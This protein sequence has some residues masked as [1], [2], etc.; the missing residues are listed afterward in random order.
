MTI[1][2]LA[3][4]IA[5]SAFGQVMRSSAWAYPLAN[6][7]HLFGLAMLA[8]GILAVDLRIMGFG[9]KLPLKAMHDALTPFAIF[10]LLLFALSGVALFAA[11]AKE[12]VRN[13]VFLAKMVIV[14]LAVANALAFRTFASGGL[15]SNDLP[16]NLRLSAAISLSLWSAAIICGR[17]IAY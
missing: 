11:D 6:V 7:A 10:G 1:Q 17:M 5:A 4:D 13:P 8:G 3:S 12:L 14:T 15:S 2:A 16:F 9:R